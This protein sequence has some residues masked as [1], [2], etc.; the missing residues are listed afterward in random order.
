MEKNEQSYMMG[1]VSTV[2]VISSIL[3]VIGVIYVMSGGRAS[4]LAQCSGDTGDSGNKVS[5]KFEECLDSGKYDDK[6]KADQAQGLQLGVNG[7]P[8]TFINGYL[9]SGALPFE[10]VADVIDTILAG[11][12]PNQE[13]LKDRE[14]GEITKVEMPQITQED[15]QIGAKNGQ[16]SFVIY[17]DFECPFCSK[18]VPTVDQVIENYG[19]KVT[20]VFKHFPLSFHQVAIPAAIATE[21]AAEQGKFWEMHDKLFELSGQ[22]S[23]TLANVKK[24]GS[25]LGLK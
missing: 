14:T 21:C 3:L 10:A 25:D 15:H 12:E 19:D 23:L 2:A 22:G 20:V 1:I 24:A 18:Y 4:C 17:S 11:N 7:T 9:V 6:I 13:F 5:K 16:I 8:A